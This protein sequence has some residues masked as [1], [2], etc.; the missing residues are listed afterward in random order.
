M[1]RGR[2]E[3]TP[4]TLDRAPDQAGRTVLVT[5]ANSGIGLETA[6]AL[7]RLGARVVLGCRN[8][9]RAEGA[10]ADLLASVPGARIEILR[11]DLADLA[12]V[13][14]AATRAHERFDRLDLL[15][16]NAGLM[17]SPRTVTADGFEANLGTNFLGHFALTGLLLDLVEAA[18][19]GR[20]VTVGSLAHRFGRI[21]FADPQLASHF[22]VAK[23]YAQS[24]LAEVMF[25]LALDR[26]LRASRARSISVAAHPGGSRTAVLR[27]QNALLRL[28]ISSRMRAL[29][30][31]LVQEPA[32]GALPIL[33]AA[34]DPSVA[35]G[36]YYGPGGLLE[37]TGPPAPAG[38][39]RRA[40]D[41]ADQDRLWALAEGL[42]G[43][44]YGRIS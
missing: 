10:R 32:A 34:T 6:R 27:D 22:T 33:R 20:V 19:S 1:I 5:G 14:D 24:K 36:D 41:G 42:T 4:W 3:R 37:L 17:R 13:R 39:A 40:R 9:V 35:G 7:A 44:R 26:R 43:V 28:G 29:T 23:A 15:V 38:I 25:A 18:P 12:S 31:R 30:T 21:H 11:V 2:V 8:E 16:D